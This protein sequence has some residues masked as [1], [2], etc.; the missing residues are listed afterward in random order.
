MTNKPKTKLS[1]KVFCL[2]AA[3]IAACCLLTYA[4]ILR[5]APYIYQSDPEKAYELTELLA[6]EL[7]FVGYEEASE[8]LQIYQE[9]IWEELNFEFDLHLFNNNGDELDIYDLGEKTGDRIEDYDENEYF[10]M[11]NVE[12]ADRKPIFMLLV[13]ENVEK[14]SQIALALDSAAPIVTGVIFAGSL[15][16]ALFI[17]VIITRPIKRLYRISEQMER[18]DFNVEYNDNRSDEIGVLGRNLK[19]LAFKL[20]GA[21]EELKQANAKLSADIEREKELEKLQND[22]FAAASHELKTPITIIKGNLEGMLYNIGR[23]ADR[24]TYLAHSLE[25]TERLG[26]LTAEILSLT[27]M[28]SSDFNFDYTQINLSDLIYKILFNMRGLFEQKQITLYT[29]IKKATVI[30]RD[31]KL[32]EK[33]ISNILSNAVRHSPNGESVY[34]SLNA[35]EDAVILTVENTGVHIS[36]SEIKRLFE[37]F[38]RTD[39]SRSGKTGGSGLGLYIVKRAADII[40][41]EVSIFNTESGVAVKLIFKDL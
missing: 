35:E 11:Q 36:E 19:K 34:L 27:K 10:I 23:F 18:L 7:E 2:S 39:A 26:E 37:P 21:L 33:I 8:Y 22:F 14:Q 30:F 24:E 25:T 13:T 6:D 28:Q 40:N 32:C 38:Y 41:A 1:V 12:F 16:A 20:S 3:I 4:V 5:Y 31:W 17:T 29:D 15:I 9:T